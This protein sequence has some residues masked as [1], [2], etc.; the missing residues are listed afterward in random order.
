[1]PLPVYACVYRTALRLQI[2]N[3]SPKQQKCCY[4]FFFQ[5]RQRRKTLCSMKATTIFLK[6][7]Y[8]KNWRLQ[9]WNIYKFTSMHTI[10]Y[11]ETN[12]NRKGRFFCRKWKF[13]DNKLRILKVL[14]SRIIFSPESFTWAFFY[15]NQACH[16]C[17]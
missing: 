6:T 4:T 8:D 7:S 9:C 14:K 11:I 15:G 13:T 1:M 12:I 5:L 10:T 2:S 17:T 16:N 3:R